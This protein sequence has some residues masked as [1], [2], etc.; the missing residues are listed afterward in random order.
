MT[1]TELSPGRRKAVLILLA[2]TGLVVVM[3]LTI[4]NVA[5]DTIQRDLDASTAGLQWALDSYLITF[6]AFIFTSGVCADRFGR[7]KTLL[8][9]IV[10]FGVA[11][12]F[13]AYSGTIGELILWRAVMG[14][15]AA[16]VPTVTLAILINAF[17]PAERPKAIGAWAGAAGVAIAVG[18]LAGGLLLQ[19]FWWGSVFLINVPLV[20][21]GVVLIAWLVPE[22]RNPQNTKFDPAG[23]VLSILAVGALVYGIVTGGERN[24]WLAPPVIGSLVAGVAL[25]A[26]LV[27]VERRIAT[28]ALD[29]KLLKETKFTAGTMSIALAFFAM[30]GALFIT[31]LYFQAVHGFSPRTA[32][33]LMLPMGV[34]TVIM[35]TRSPKLAMKFG[36]KAVVIGG[37]LGMAV[38]FAAFSVVGAD[39]NIWV[40]AAVQLVY[41]LGWGCITAPATAALMSVVP[42]VKA[43]A[44]QAVSGTVRQ[45]AGALGVAVVGSVLG[46]VYRTTIGSTVDVLPEASRDAAAGSLGA[47]LRAITAAGGD[48]ATFG[49]LR[50]E[51]LNAYL[52]GMQV[53]M[54][55]CTA[56]SL[57]A[58]F[59]ALRWLPGK[60]PAAPVAA[61][62]APAAAAP[63]R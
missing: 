7:K 16:V 40:L 45:V 39:T 13:A 52:S 61:A 15:G 38:A 4:L 36:P 8:A 1:N 6:A 33:L 43:G 48:P 27:V 30:I 44:G 31:S 32:G 3:D 47:T 34:G 14:V 12:A 2:L 21:I 24:D 22:S 35:S 26:L 50:T 20:V 37:S 51:A 62:A 54:L 59:V 63:A 41:G 49:A 17:P 23:V 53:T 46:V 57:G 19:S 29:V 10:I 11:S 25:I 42:P 18:P 56:F 55:L 28:P 5:L 58:A 9:G 60:P